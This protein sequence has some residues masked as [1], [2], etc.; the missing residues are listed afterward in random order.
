MKITNI[1]IEN[2]RSI[3]NI[4]IKINHITALIGQKN[5]GGRSIMTAINLF[6][7]DQ[8]LKI[9][10][11]YEMNKNL[12]I[13][14]TA[15]FIQPE[16]DNGKLLSPC[17]NKNN[18]TFQ[19][20]CYFEN[21]TIQTEIRLF[22]HTLN[23]YKVIDTG[24]WKNI[25]H[26]DMPDIIYIPAVEDTTKQSKN[27][28]RALFAKIF[29]QFIEVNETPYMD[30][31][32]V[33]QGHHS[34]DM[35]DKINKDFG[36]VLTKA[37]DIEFNTGAEID[38]TNILGKS[39]NIFLIEEPDLYVHPL[40]HRSLMTIFN[41]MPIQNQIIFSTNSPDFIDILDYQNMVLVKKSL[42]S[43]YIQQIRDEIFNEEEKQNFAQL[44][45]FN[46]Y[47]RDLFF[48]RK[49]ILVEELNDMIILNSLIFDE[50]L[51]EIADLDFGELNFSINVCGGKPGIKYWEKILNE[52]DIKYAVVL[53]DQINDKDSDNR[54]LNNEI[55]ILCNNNWYWCFLPDHETELRVFRH[56]KTG[57]SNIISD[58]FKYYNEFAVSNVRF[59]ET[60]HEILEWIIN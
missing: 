39:T 18:V 26:T 24:E 14:I 8:T 33:L 42:N 52:M 40:M 47:N 43:T 35:I 2:Y 36:E 21:G 6:F 50:L 12:E 10:D 11:F 22:N 29:S 9:D 44:L 45:K 1:Q 16:E 55:K 53:N 4:D 25:L 60:L 30:Y 46:S 19:K 48:T 51:F 37:I 17:I 49:V 28:S 58:P 3:A 13:K 32:E 15:T 7:T 54:M 57:K 38:L 20:R 31:K 5:A 23:T 27:S 56:E 34:N 41:K 59:K